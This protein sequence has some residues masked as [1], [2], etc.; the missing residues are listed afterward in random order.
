MNELKNTGHR[1]PNLDLIK[2]IACIGVVGL[3]AVGMKNYTIYYLC[4]ISV[5][6]FFMVN[7]FLMFQKQDIRYSYIL[8]KIGMILAVV[9][10]WNVLM[11][12]PVYL[13]RHKLSN[14]FL[15]TGLSL[16]Q[17]GYLWH[18]WFF[19]S[20]LL[21]YLILPVIHK[22]LKEHQRIHI[23]ICGTLF[24]VSIGFM[25]WSM[26]QKTSM[27]LYVPQ[28]LRLWIWLF[29]YLFGGL[30][31]TLRS[32]KKT[33]RL[34]L[35]IHGLLVIMLAVF[36]NIAAK[37]IGFYFVQNR[38]MECF[39]DECL[40]ILYSVS[41]FTFFLRISVKKCQKL[42]TTLSSVTM[43]IY[44]IHPILLF[45]AESM[46][47]PSSLAAILLFWLGLTVLSGI[48]AFIMKQLPIIKKLVSL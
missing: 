16:L 26:Y 38:L 48:L 13:F 4:G 22:F 8:R 42:I 45:V 27:E 20:L 6:F 31:G 30:M 19:G 36:A 12:V 39:Y 33:V 9:F 46:T 24:P 29:Y 43:G 3:H 11:M 21:I 10:A 15:Q 2:C 37:R 40:Q 34:P 5:P 18:F 23:L 32:S 35:W 17:K 25:I 28:S 44:I 41:A 7:G 47:L 14:P 1:N